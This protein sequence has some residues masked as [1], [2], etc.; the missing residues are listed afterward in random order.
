MHTPPTTRDL[1]LVAYVQF[2][3]GLAG[4]C[5][6]WAM[7]APQEAWDVNPYFSAWLFAAGLLAALLRPRSFYWGVLG[8]YLGQ[9]AALYAFIPGQGAIFPGVVAV[10]FFGTP[11]AFVGALLGAVIG[12]GIQRLI[13]LLSPQH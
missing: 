4:G 6:I 10:L 3:I 12:F 13:R 5:I 1:T 9:V 11:Q 7:T 8:V 2:G